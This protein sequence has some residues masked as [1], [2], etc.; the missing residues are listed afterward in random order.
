VEKKKDAYSRGGSTS[1]EGV[2]RRPRRSALQ[3]RVYTEGVTSRQNL[4]AAVVPP[5]DGE[6]KRSGGAMAAKL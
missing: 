6:R 4:H 3:A 5:P 1:S 2:R